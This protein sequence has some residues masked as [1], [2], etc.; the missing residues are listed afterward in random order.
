[1]S[2]MVRFI[3]EGRPV[4]PK[5]ARMLTEQQESDRRIDAIME[6]AWRRR[7]REYVDRYRR[8]IAP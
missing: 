4:D 3:T 5:L 7:W 6:G 2:G 1:M 8:E